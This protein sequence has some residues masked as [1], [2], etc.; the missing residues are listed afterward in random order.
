M[1]E[2]GNNV[3][4]LVHQLLDEQQC[5]YKNVIYQYTQTT[6]AYNSNRIEGSKLSHEHTVNLFNTH[7]I[8]SSGNEVINSNDIIETMNHFRAF[9]FM[10]KN[11]DSPTDETFIKELHRILKTN[12][13][14]ADL[15]WFNVGEYKSLPNTI[16][17]QETCPPDQDK[18]RAYC[19]KLVKDF[20]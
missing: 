3:E 19:Q 13:T 1:T 12:T 20:T 16:G 5:Q 7:T 11:Y 14:D 6:L 4:K 2:S 8:L 9:D 18:Y 15:D 17:D 10:L